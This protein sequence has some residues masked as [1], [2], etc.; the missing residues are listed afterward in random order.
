MVFLCVC[1]CVFVFLFFYFV[2]VAFFFSSG[3]WH[4][5]V[6]FSEIGTPKTL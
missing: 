3:C 6:P 2:I 4:Q 5:R 1:V